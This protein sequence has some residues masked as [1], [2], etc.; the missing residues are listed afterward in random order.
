MK[1][2]LEALDK[3]DGIDGAAY[4]KAVEKFHDDEL[5][6]EMFLQMSDGRK[7]D[8]VLNLK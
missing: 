2:S 8:W 7:K 3:L 6:R 5:W 4:A 1:D